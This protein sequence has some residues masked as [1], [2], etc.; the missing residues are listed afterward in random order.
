LGLDDL[1]HPR[2]QF[3]V[4]SSP[5]GVSAVTQN[6]ARNSRGG[7]LVRFETRT[8]T[9]SAQ[10]G[11]RTVEAARCSQHRPPSAGGRPWTSSR[12]APGRHV[13]SLPQRPQPLPRPPLFPFFP[14]SLP[15]RQPDS[16]RPHRKPTILHLLL[17]TPNLSF[18]P[19]S[20]PS[21]NTPHQQD[22]DRTVNSG[23]DC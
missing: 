16:P 11:H 15:L 13:A 10:L 5:T 3:I 17:P 4:P 8:R 22:F 20:A 19:S 18:S 14:P 9:E 12:P 2:K 7:D 23:R 21:L 1:A 6:A